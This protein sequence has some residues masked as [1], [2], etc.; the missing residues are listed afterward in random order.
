MSSVASASLYNPGSDYAVSAFGLPSGFPSSVSFDITG[1][2]IISENSSVGVTASYDGTPVT[3]LVRKYPRNLFVASSIGVPARFFVVPDFVVVQP[4]PPLPST[5][6]TSV[7]VLVV[8]GGGGGAGIGGAAGG[9]GG[10]GGVRNENVLVFA[11]SPIT[12]I[13]GAGGAA[14][15]ILDGLAAD[16]ENS[17]FGAILSTGGGRG[18]FGNEG[19]GS[20]GS[21]GG[22]NNLQTGGAGTAGQGNNG[23]PGNNLGAG[24]GGGKN[25]PGLAAN[26]TAGGAGGAAF[27][28]AISGNNLGYGGG[29]GGGGVLDAPG[30][31]AG[32]GGGNGGSNTL[33]AGIPAPNRGGGGGGATQTGL[34]PSAGA[35]GV[36]IVSYSESFTAAAST[37]GSPSITISGGNRIY[38]WIN[39]G[40]ITF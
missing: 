28:S 19:A 4:P 21:G 5:S 8:A 1:S 25:S 20:G 30:G 13:V 15:R 38:R 9:G 11:G 29:G 34:P 32:D 24:G 6:P 26:F 31:I 7:N 18:A 39:S 37:T 12:I 35:A 40:S 2:F 33:A 14:A 17:A 16:G 3:S 27:F 23:G 22:D 10:A 36:V